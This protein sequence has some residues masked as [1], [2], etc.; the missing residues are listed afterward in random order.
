MI[1][2]CLCLAVVTIIAMYLLASCGDTYSESTTEPFAGS[3]LGL[4]TIWGRIDGS[5]ATI[6]LTAALYDK[7]GGDGSPPVHNTTAAAYDNLISKQ[8]D[9]IFVTYPSENEF[10]MARENG[11]ELEI[12][13]VTKDALVFLVNIENP[14]D[15]ISLSDIRDIYTGKISNWKT[16]GGADKVIAPYQRT[17]DSGSQT[18]LL[19][20]AMDGQD[21]MN[22]LTNWVAEAMGD[23]VEVISGYDNTTE[24]I[25]YSVFYYVNNMYGNNR[26][27]L[28]DIDGVKPTRDT[29]TSGEYPLEDYY[30]A[31]IRKDTPADSPA[32]KLIDWL[33]TDEGQTLA[34]RSGYI[35]LRPLEGVLSDDSIDPIYLG[36]VDFS[37][38]T[39]GTALK[40]EEEI[41]G[42]ITNGVRKPL[43]DVFFDEFNYI[44]YINSEIAKQL[45]VTKEDEWMLSF[46][47]E[48]RY[49]KRPFSGIPSDYPNYELRAYG[50]LTIN[51]PA[52]NPFFVGAKS[53][54]FRL[55]EDISPY[56]TGLG[57]Y[58][59]SYHYAGR[60]LPNIDLFTNKIEIPNTPDISERINT[61]LQ[62][63]SDAFPGDVDKVRLLESFSEWYGS[64]PEHPYRLQPLTGLWGNYLS[65][66]YVL[67]TYD[68]PSTHMPAMYTM[69]FDITTGDVV[70]LPDVLPRGL[71][72]A[73][74][75]I[76]SLITRFE[77]KFSEG[78]YPSTEYFDSYVPA[79][80]FVIDDAWLLGSMLGI[81]VTE[82]SG[83][84]L[85]VFFYG[86][87]E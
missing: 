84:R 41:D 19:K 45:L 25:G 47:G 48:D 28:L 14:V 13:P 11:V 10:N 82:P 74:S 78:D 38:G 33:L 50:H 63:W 66:S 36:D 2:K 44:Q 52:E 56:G 76:Q 5:T 54:V 23:L 61:R 12:I 1:K 17:T 62:T 67:Q 55:S 32:R 42:M 87:W 73:E 59:V 4:H 83:Q 39:G 71:P 65:V 69:C 51:F 57:V 85:Q 75:Q 49:T 37:S 81:H 68:G 6:P 46:S 9:L 43:S 20:L 24:A 80:G 31:V 26:F 72:F 58:K 77:G 70:N 53:F 86:D 15:N 3:I 16:F 30:Y 7:L 35:P 60:M 40:N 64:T 79:D 8:S 18:L 22:P 34:V 21:P 27:K 29:I